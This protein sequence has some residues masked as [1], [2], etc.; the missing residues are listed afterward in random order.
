MASGPRQNIHLASLRSSCSLS[1]IE[2]MC[3]VVTVVLPSIYRRYVLIAL[4]AVLE[5]SQLR[6]C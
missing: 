4:A 1:A 6:F 5:V 3:I 2:G